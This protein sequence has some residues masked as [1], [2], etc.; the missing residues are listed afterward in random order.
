M[1]PHLFPFPFFM[2]QQ[3]SFSALSP[4]LTKDSTCEKKLLIIIPEMGNCIR[5][6]KGEITVIMLGLMG[7]AR[8]QE[9]NTAK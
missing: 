1:S 5:I 7:S 4:L 2:A 9:E 6:N 3:I 8:N